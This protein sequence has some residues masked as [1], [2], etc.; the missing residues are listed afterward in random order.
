MTKFS[1]IRGPKGTNKST[2][3]TTQLTG[4][5]YLPGT[6][7]HAVFEAMPKP[8]CTLVEYF[9]ALT[10]AGVKEHGSK[11]LKQAAKRGYIN[12]GGAEFK[13]PEVSEVL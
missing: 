10:K 7:Q 11:T 2:V 6:P 9:E 12:M 1:R 13:A 8:F 5:P 4:N 3:I